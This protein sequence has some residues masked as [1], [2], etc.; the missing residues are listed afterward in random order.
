MWK[1]KSVTFQ[2]LISYMLLLIVPI[3]ISGSVFVALNSNVKKNAV[4]LNDIILQSLKKDF[5]SNIME[6]RNAH[7]ELSA[8]SNLKRII[9]GVNLS[10]NFDKK[11]AVNAWKELKSLINTNSS[12]K[13]IYVNF[14]QKNIAIYT[15]S[16]VSDSDTINQVAFPSEKYE[17]VEKFLEQ[18]PR[19]GFCGLSLMEEESVSDT[20][21]YVAP[22]PIGTTM[23]RMRAIAVVCMNMDYFESKI[24][25]MSNLE[26]SNIALF[27]KNDIC[28]YSANE[29]VKIDISKKEKGMYD[30]KEN[31]VSFINLDIKGWYFAAVTPKKLFWQN[32]NVVRLMCLFGLALS[33]ILGGLCV[34]YLLRKNYF[35]LKKVVDYVVQKKGTDDLSENEYDVLLS[36][37]DR[38]LASENRAKRSMEKQER[39]LMRNYFEKLLQG[40]SA[41]WN[42]DDIGEKAGFLSDEFM[43]AIFNVKNLDE[44]F[45]D[46]EMTQGER[47]ETA[48]LIISNVMEELLGKEHLCYVIEHNGFFVALI[49]LSPDVEDAEKD[50]IDVL[51]FGCQFIFE[52]FALKINTPVGNMHLGL[53]GISQS[54]RQAC[55]ILDYAD[56]A[57]DSGVIEYKSLYNK[58][59][60]NDGYL[61]PVDK[62]AQLMN[63]IRLGAFDTAKEILDEIFELNIRE[64]K[65][66]FTIFKCLALEIS[67]TLLK[68]TNDTEISKKISEVVSLESISAIKDGIINVAQKLCEQS[69][70][71]T[72]PVENGMEERIKEYIAQNYQDVNLCVQSIGNHFDMQGYYLSKLFKNIT[73]R[74]ILDY[75]RFIRTEQAKKLI[76]E[77]PYIKI[78]KVAELVGFAN[79]RALSRAFKQSYGIMP[80]EYKKNNV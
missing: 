1:K 11:D 63:S 74:G 68:L 23:R 4:N 42:F 29:D 69:Y 35:P 67:G 13:S 27:D 78:E 60:L 37:I 17:Q 65:I 44:L 28:V 12:V 33:I 73:G 80:G 64:K 36:V 58:Q 46:E 40:Q 15:G 9:N 20:V 54:Y 32:L 41:K 21:A 76:D 70:V 5:D 51:N 19:G 56:F 77:N 2:W 62:E 6:L 57:E 39:L 10:E 49:S 22:L 79:V 47:F 31:V 59:S 71:N 43:T 38:M 66:S 48:Q 26:G 7:I 61:Y 25:G 30:D 52:K 18:N 14:P 24:I 53:E 55:E 34:M 75:I 72:K 8:N 3:V 16:G 50:V 45:P